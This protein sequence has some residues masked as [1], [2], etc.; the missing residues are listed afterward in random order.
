MATNG[1]KAPVARRVWIDAQGNPC[2]EHEA[3]GFRY[4][5]VTTALRLRPDFDWETD[6]APKEAVFELLTLPEPTKTMTAIFGSL[7]LAGNIASSETNAKS[8]GDPDSNPIPAIA[9]RFADMQDNKWTGEKGDRGPRY[10]HEA[11]AKAI[12]QV[13]GEQDH[14]PY[15]KRLN[16]KEKVQIKGKGA[17]L[18][19]AF[20]MHNDQVKEIYNKLTGATPVVV[21]ASD[22]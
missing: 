2:D 1:K 3:T 15:L 10:D 8:G 16:E 21:S 12:A 20:A 13:K 4:I 9:A 19:A 7:T 5:H 6:E 14:N 11:L 17:I 18:Y 22:L